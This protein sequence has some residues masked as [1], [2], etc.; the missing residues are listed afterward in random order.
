MDLSF[1]NQVT[2]DALDSKN[3]RTAG[4]PIVFY[5]FFDNNWYHD[6]KALTANHPKIN[7]LTKTRASGQSLKQGGCVYRYVEMLD[8]VIEITPPRGTRSNTIDSFIEEINEA[9]INSEYKFNANHDKLTRLLNRNGFECELK[10]ISLKNS[11]QNMPVEEALVTLEYAAVITLDIDHFKQINDTHLHEYGDIVLKSFAWRIAEYVKTL[12]K[13]Y[14]VKVVLGRI[15]GEEFDLFVYGIKEVKAVDEIAENLRKHIESEVIPSPEQVKLLK[16]DE[17]DIPRDQERRVTASIGYS[18]MQIK[19]TTST[20]EVYF[21]QKKRADTALYKAKSNGR[22]RAINHDEIRKIHGRVFEH[23]E[24]TDIVSIDIG[25]EVG[26]KVGAVYSVTSPNYSGGIP[27]IVDDKRTQKKIGTYPK[28]C[29]GQL[30]IIEVQEKISFCRIIGKSIN[31]LFP[32]D[33]KIEYVPMG[34]IRPLPPSLSPSP[35]PTILSFYDFSAALSNSVRSN[36]WQS[37]FTFRL[38]KQKTEKHFPKLTSTPEQKRQWSESISNLIRIE[39]PTS[40]IG[41]VRD[42]LLVAFHE[43]AATDHNSNMS[44]AINIADISS[45]QGLVYCGLVEKNSSQPETLKEII[46]HAS[47]EDLIYFARLAG[48]VSTARQKKGGKEPHCVSFTE[49]VAAD[50]IYWVRSLGL[51]EDALIDYHKL[52][53]LGVDSCDFHNQLALML[54]FIG[55]NESMGI[56]EIT[57]SKLI[58]RKG[59][60]SVQWYI[61]CNLAY[62]K[63]FLGKYAEA[64]DLFSNIDYMNIRID[65]YRLAYFKSAYEVEKSEPTKHDPNREITLNKLAEKCSTDAKPYNIT[66]VSWHKECKAYAKEHTATQSKGAAPE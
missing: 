63:T 32:K 15:G 44:S 62:I 43:E 53:R 22:N 47:A 9:L 14:N 4:W 58:S 48:Y 16:L 12:N 1:Y 41:Y 49:E 7:P 17:S 39:F 66:E 37:L 26:V 65:T 36:K 51:L 54:M 24:D 2:K 5:R 25:S 6:S 13:K 33:S 18:T 30:S 55:D 29:S 59:I 35:I 61:K 3:L 31:G 10:K 57:L 64:Y 19:Q 45:P 28:I 34:I 11:P 40:T 46:Q 23:Y 50:A 20:L 8:A 21:K 38:L 27:I 52:S 42:D 60:G 56:A